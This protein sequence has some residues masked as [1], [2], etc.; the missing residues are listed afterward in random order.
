[1]QS[2]TETTQRQTLRMT[3]CI[4]VYRIDRTS[5]R[6]SYF[7]KHDP[8]SLTL[9]LLCLERQTHIKPKCSVI[10]ISFCGRSNAQG[11]N[12]SSNKQESSSDNIVDP[13]FRDLDSRAAHGFGTYFISRRKYVLELSS[14]N[15]IGALKTK[16]FYLEIESHEWK[17]TLI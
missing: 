7:G 2:G 15:R 9:T 8:F 6:I 10:L 17:H 5:K 13:N 3:H 11:D 14:C 4:T 12:C 1:M 16:V